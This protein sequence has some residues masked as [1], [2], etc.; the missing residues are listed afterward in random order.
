MIQLRA[1]WPTTPAQQARGRLFNPVYAAMDTGDLKGNLKISYPSGSR[2]TTVVSVAL[3][4]G[5]LEDI[6][7][8]HYSGDTEDCRITQLEFG[9]ILEARPEVLEAVRRASG[10]DP[11]TPRPAEG[12]A[13]PTVSGAGPPS[14][15]A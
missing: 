6:A 14:G 1:S 7:K 2:V 11:P 12:T 5:G 15:S 4:D 8:V 3:A 9:G 13:T 10:L